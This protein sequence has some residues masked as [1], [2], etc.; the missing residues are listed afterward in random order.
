MVDSYLIH[1]QHDN[2]DMVTL[3]MEHAAMLAVQNQVKLFSYLLHHLS[4]CGSI[5][6][7]VQVVNW[8]SNGGYTPL[9]IAAINQASQVPTPCR[10]RNITSVFLSPR[11]SP[12]S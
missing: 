7:A 4:P 1:L 3:L 8:R 6:L 10:S 11:P 5:E 2:V 12:Y 9:H